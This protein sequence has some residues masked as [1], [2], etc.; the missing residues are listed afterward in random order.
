MAEITYAHFHQHYSK[1]IFRN[2]MSHNLQPVEEN[3]G[4]VKFYQL[5]YNISSIFMQT[6]LQHKTKSS[7]HH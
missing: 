5:F 6:T 7:Y 1:Y 4:N 2:S 3:K